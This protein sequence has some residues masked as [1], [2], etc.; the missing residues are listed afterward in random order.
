LLVALDLIR[1]AFAGE[2]SITVVA[3]GAWLWCHVATEGFQWVTGETG[4]SGEIRNA[5]GSPV[6]Q[7]IRSEIAAKR[8]G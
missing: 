7:A 3:A 4:V 6:D 5:G 2:V 1:G 8:C